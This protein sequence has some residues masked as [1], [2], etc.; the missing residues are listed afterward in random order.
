M[1]NKPAGNQT[2]QSEDSDVGEGNRYFFIPSE[3]LELDPATTG[4]TPLS[5]F[6]SHNDEPLITISRD[7]PGWPE[8]ARLILHALNA[9]R[10]EFANENINRAR[11]VAGMIE[12]EYNGEDREDAVV[13]ALADLHHLC[14]VENWQFERL[15]TQA[16]T[17]YLTDLR[18]SATSTTL[19]S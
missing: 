11:R 13:I 8:R 5:I 10:P 14:N 16:R 7:V 3:A 6:E 17:Q 12:S 18:E 4:D 19:N 2:N 1:K 15:E 9:G